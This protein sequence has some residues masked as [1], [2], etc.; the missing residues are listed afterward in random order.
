MYCHGENN[1]DYF[2]TTD[3]VGQLRSKFKGT[4]LYNEFLPVMCTLILYSAADKSFWSL[5]KARPR[6]TSSLK[7]IYN[8]KEYSKHAMPGGFLCPSTNISFMMNTD[9]VSIFRSSKTEVWPIFLVINELPA[10]VR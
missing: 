3:F 10:S 4:A 9:G 2:I 1:V 6:P 5:L 8:G 7:D